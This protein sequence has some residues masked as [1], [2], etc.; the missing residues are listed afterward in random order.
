MNGKWLFLISV[1]LNIIAIIFASSSPQ[2]ASFAINSSTSD[3][4]NYFVLGITGQSVPTM[5][6]ALNS[7]LSSTLNA[8]QQTVSFGTGLGGFI[9]TVRLVLT[10]AG[11]FTP[12][13]VL[14]VWFTMQFPSL[15]LLLF[16]IPYALLYIIAWMEFLRG[17]VL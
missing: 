9:D 1:C 12:I 15:F 5:T 11:L 2:Y 14:T 4:N 16:G 10:L 3:L 8:N 6:S 17:G 7:S 13:P